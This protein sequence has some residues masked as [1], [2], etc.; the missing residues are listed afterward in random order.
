[1]EIRPITAEDYEAHRHI[2]SLAFA[3][4]KTP[5]F[6]SDVYEQTDRTRIGVYENGRLQ[7][8]LGILDFELLFGEGRRP[9]GAIFGVAS[10]PAMRGRGFAGA[11][12][13]RCLRI[14]HERGQFLSS[15]WPFDF[16]YYRGYGWEWTGETRHYAVPLELIPSTPEADR[17]EGVYEDA[18]PCLNSIYER[19]AARYHGMLVRSPKRWEDLTGMAG[20]RRRAVYVYRRDNDEE[21]YMILRYGEKEDELHADELIAL[22]RRAYAGLLGVARRHAMTAKKLLYSAPM[23]DPLRAILNHWDVETRIEP[24]GMG[25]VVDAKAALEAI[26]PPEDARGEA[27]V[28]IADGRAPWNEGTW[29]IVAEGGRVEAARTNRVPGVALD[30]QAL[31]QAYWGTPSL[32]ELRRWERVEPRDESQFALL[33]R[34][35]PSAPAWLHD[36]F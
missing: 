24:S 27:V 9:C 29:R 20:G 31:T 30:I 21:G 33:A 5:E 4:G 8:V 19:M 25:R 10:D 23:D 18:I 26:R 16:R 34:I 28:S 15:L 13:T 32:E 14:M 17:V 2:V 3:R 11:L 36:D 6:T 7:A 1:M 22:T 12:L 35:L